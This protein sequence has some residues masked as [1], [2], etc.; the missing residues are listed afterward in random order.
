MRCDEAARREA[1]LAS[2]TPPDLADAYLAA[3]ADVASRLDRG[4]IWACPLGVE[5]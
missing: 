5:G 2:G 1:L 4:D 3:R